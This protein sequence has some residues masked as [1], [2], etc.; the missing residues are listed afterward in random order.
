MHSN[1]N[2]RNKVYECMKKA[3]GEKS[4]NETSVLFTPVG[5]YLGDDVLEGFTADAEFLGKP[6]ECSNNFDRSFYNLCKLDNCFIFDFTAAED[7]V[8]IPPMEISQLDQILF[9][10]MKPGSTISL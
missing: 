10:K 4:S 2:N 7:Q 5:Q 6:N 8:K 3:R 9:T 1:K